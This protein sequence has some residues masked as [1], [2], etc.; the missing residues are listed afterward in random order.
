MFSRTCIIECT[1]SQYCFFISV[2]VAPGPVIAFTA[3]LTQN[4]YPMGPH[5]T[6]IFDSV[7]TD[8][9]DAYHEHGGLFLPPVSGVYVLAVTAMVPGGH[10]GGVDIVKN[11]VE[12]CR[13]FGG[14]HVAG[15]AFDTPGTCVVTVHLTPGDDVLVQ[16]HYN[17]ALSSYLKG[18]LWSSFTGFLL[19]AG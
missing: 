16:N 17:D 5:Q 7:V 4:M 1:I 8:I 2:R 3:R 11:G 13:A 12:L 14:D 9:G 19:V 18:G 10:S 6:V 15:S